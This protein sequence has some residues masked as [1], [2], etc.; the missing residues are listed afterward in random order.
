[1]RRREL[2]LSLAAPS[3][4]QPN[5]ILIMTDDHGHADLGC[6]GARD[7]KTPHIDALARGGVRLTNWYSNAPVCAPSR[8]ALLTGRYPHH[9][10]VATNGPKLPRQQTTLATALKRLGYA[11]AVCGKWH[12][13]DA[14]ESSPR[15]HG[16]DS[17][18]GFHSGC[19][20]FY[21]HRFYWNDPKVVNYHD[22]WRDQTEIFEDGQYLT[23]RIAAESAAFIRRNRTRP[24][25]LYV[26]FNA[27]HYPMHA[28]AK[29]VERFPGLEP[30]RRMYAAML[31]AVDDGVGEIVKAVREGK[32]ERE[33]IIIFTSDNGAT[34]ERR[35]GLNQEMAAAGSNA[36]FRGSKF[37]LFDGGIHLPCIWWAPGRLPAGSVNPQFGAHF[38]IHPTV[39]GA[40]GG[41]SEGT[42]RPEGVNL[43][44]ALV[45]GRPVERGA[46]YWTL[47]N[48]QAMREGDWK[49]VL[50]GLDEGRAKPDAVHLANLARDPGETTNLA[51][52][53][54]ERT[55][56]MRAAL[57]AWA[58]R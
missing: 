39:L 43:W 35:A 8:A 16:F 23:E 54:P 4:R 36:P 53:E 7:L 25:F 14:K 45:S 24:F 21:S 55:A 57:E 40:V 44:P 31:A 51:S 28:P 50:N 22:L 48:Q 2:L 20:D 15:D 18:Y 9:A 32:L 56:R 37:S 3:A 1:M 5:V 47:G 33:T 49:L 29:Y 58:A 52:Q 41:A 30:E 26:P 13:G 12:L 17:F 34:R 11:T 19:V 42:L 6:Q 10:G 46:V 38:D 27:P